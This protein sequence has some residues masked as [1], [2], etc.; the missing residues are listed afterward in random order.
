MSEKIDIPIDIYD[1]EQEIV[2]IAPLW[3]VNKKSIEVFLER[4]DL[5]IKWERVLP[6]LKDTLEAVKQECFR[7]SFSNTIPL[8]QNVYFDK[9]QTKFT[10]ENI[11]LIIVPKIIIPE[12]LKIELD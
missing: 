5:F 3:W 2:I 11:L 4:T 10:W 12:K 9:I 7:W 1:S 8:P 6:D